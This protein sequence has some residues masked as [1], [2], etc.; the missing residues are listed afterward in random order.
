MLQAKVYAYRRFRVGGRVC[1]SP[2]AERRPGS[3]SPDAEKAAVSL[4]GRNEPF[5]TKRRLLQ[6][7]GMSE[8]GAYT[9]MRDFAESVASD[10]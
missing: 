6:R 1:D 7:D 3:W 4:A 8:T 9:D 10:T 2:N 5:G